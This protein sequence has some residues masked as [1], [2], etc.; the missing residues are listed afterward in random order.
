M[1]G[2]E[3]VPD[4]FTAVRGMRAPGLAIPRRRKIGTWRGHGRKRFVDVRRGQP[5]LVVRL[6]GQR[7]DELLLGSDTAEQLVQRL[8]AGAGPAQPW[9]PAGPP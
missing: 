1:T 2:V 6:A 4:G 8:R 7:Y 9:P 5:A 3:V